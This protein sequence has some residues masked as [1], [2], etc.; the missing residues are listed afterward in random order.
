TNSTKI[1]YV[2]DGHK[3]YIAYFDPGIPVNS[4]RNLQFNYGDP[5]GTPIE[6][7]WSQHPDDEVTKYKVY[8]KTKYG[9][10]M[11]IST[12]DRTGSQSHTYT[13]TDGLYSITNNT[14]SNN[15][16][17]Y[18]VRAYY[19]HSSNP[20]I[21]S[22]EDWESVY[23]EILFKQTEEELDENTFTEVLEYG[24]SNYPNPFN[25]TTTIHYQL[26]EDANVS[27]KVFDILGKQ[28]AELVNGEKGVGNHNVMFN[29]SNL[30]A[31]L[32]FYTIEAKPTNL[33]GK[34]FSKTNK[35]LLVK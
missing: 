20:A 4:Y 33:N 31:G 32:Y 34:G 29:S 35:M 27:I 14:S 19:E 3:D 22:A 13:Y 5:V 25:P 21:E 12:I 11:L 23:G 2:S 30:S 26:P 1:F 9:S 7:T 10:P 16:L 8:R 24:I 28:I 15:L 17:K 18:D 6:L